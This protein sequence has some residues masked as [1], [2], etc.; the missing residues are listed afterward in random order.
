[1]IPSF[2][3]KIIQRIKRGLSEAIHEEG[4]GLNEPYKVH[5]Y[6]S[7]S[8]LRSADYLQQLLSNFPVFSIENIQINSFDLNERFHFYFAIVP[9]DIDYI[10]EVSRDIKKAI[11]R[12][13]SCHIFFVHTHGSSKINSSTLA[14]LVKS[15]TN[16]DGRDID[17]CPSLREFLT[18]RAALSRATQPPGA[19]SMPKE[20]TSSKPVSMIM[21][22]NDRLITVY[23]DA[24]FAE[25]FFKVNGLGISHIPVLKNAADERCIKILS[26]RD[27]VKR[28]PPTRIPEEIATLSGIKRGALVRM[29]AELGNQTIQD[30]F[31]KDQ[32]I[33][34]VL[35]SISIGEVIDRL[36]KKYQIGEFERYISGLPVYVDEDSEE[37]EGFVSFRDVIKQFIS[38]Q[39]EFL[40]L[41]VKDV[42]TL[43]T[44]YEEVIRMTNSDNLSY[45]DSLFQTGI[46]SLPIVEGDYDSDV[47][48]GFVD[49]IKVNVYNHAAFTNQLANLS[50]E[51]FAT[52]VDSL[53]ILDPNE[54]LAECLS[55]FY[56]RE[57]GQSP[58]AS[59]VVGE[60]A[61]N[62]D[63]KTYTKLK[64]ILSY[65]D[66][67]KA[68]KK[69]N[70]KK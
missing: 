67:L 9:E 47:L 49:E 5:I 31:P 15:K 61:Q 43:P 42:A 4:H 68:W 46:R 18:I 3:P 23:A 62:A 50:C 14:S 48:W 66:V 56:I 55:A 6:S 21:T 69:W 1:M 19:I 38:T 52:K 70:A 65:I 29:V 44:D 16:R 13:P 40:K 63:G 58:P 54:S 28:L 45:A 34:F 64:G 17:I 60:K 51:Y 30:L 36:T 26:R 10:Y 24:K 11:E 33:E 32:K 57:E 7:K 53:R 2:H 39:A 8:D 41:K 59:F 12:R 27:I 35:P 25:V 20:L 22:P 37:L